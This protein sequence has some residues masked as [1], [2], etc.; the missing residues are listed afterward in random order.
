MF[1]TYSVIH[2]AC[3]RQLDTI[4]IWSM[5]D[6]RARKD[7]FPQ[8]MGTYLRRCSF[9]ITDFIA[10][11]SGWTLMH[12]FF[13]IP[14]CVPEPS[15]GITPFAL[16]SPHYA[17]YWISFTLLMR[18]SRLLGKNAPSMRR[19]DRRSFRTHLDTVL[20][21][22]QGH[23]PSKGTYRAEPQRCGGDGG[24][25]RW[26]GSGRSRR[27]HDEAQGVGFW[28]QST[29]HME[30]SNIVGWP[31][32]TIFVYRRSSSSNNLFWSSASFYAVLVPFSLDTL[33][34]VGSQEYQNIE[35]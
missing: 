21:S 19:F 22:F 27:R 6:I 15:R 31:V 3:P 1:G 35:E 2:I 12:R 33:T 17:R 23:Q 11:S 13:H 34:L 8:M 24:G 29:I 7:L 20:A 14:S 32:I 30:V 10:I 26:C 4:G 18:A 16:D 9:F 5:D 28:K 25:S